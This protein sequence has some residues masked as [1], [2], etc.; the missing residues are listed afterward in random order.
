MRRG[1]QYVQDRRICDAATKV[2]VPP[3]NISPVGGGDCTV[4]GNVCIA[5]SVCTGTICKV[6]LGGSGCG[7]TD[8]NCVT[9]ECTT[10][11]ICKIGMGIGVACPV[12][13]TFC[14]SP[15]V[16][17]GIC[18]V[19]LGDSGCLGAAAN[20][21]A[22]TCTA[23]D[24]SCKTG[25]ALGGSCADAGTTFCLNPN[26]CNV[27]SNI[28]VVP[29]AILPIGSG[30]CTLAGNVCV[31]GAICDD[32]GV[33]KIP[34]GDTRC[35]T[36]STICEDPADCV[37]NVCV[38]QEGETG[39]VVQADCDTGLNCLFSICVEETTD[40][41][42]GC[43]N[44][45]DCGEGEVC[46]I[47]NAVGTCQ[48]PTG[49]STGGKPWWLKP[50]LIVGGVLAAIISIILA[51]LAAITFGVGGLLFFGGDDGGDDGSGGGSHHGH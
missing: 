39:C 16:C 41:A 44:D 2:C 13:T 22:G 21:V 3:T 19:P 26:I 31:A 33:C 7:N 4:A 11:E 36:D 32:D 25:V 9:G 48:Q 15:G 46:H 35:N 1:L 47:V 27:N 38:L 45:L 20:C 51:I 29:T 5:G 37:H 14:Q 28:C 30:D 8:A 12:A 40:D 10:D 18:K 23:E 17:D 24:D 49:P 6:P 42:T 50:G 34:I 43:E